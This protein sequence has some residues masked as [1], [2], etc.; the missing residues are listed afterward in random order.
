MAVAAL[1]CILP[2]LSLLSG[3]IKSAAMHTAVHQLDGSQVP[4]FQNPAGC[5]DGNQGTD[6][7]VR[8]SSTSHLEVSSGTKHAGKDATSFSLYSRARK[9]AYK[10]AC[11]R[12][13]QHG[14]TQ[15]RGQLLTAR[16]LNAAYVSD[17]LRP[18]KPDSRPRHTSESTGQRAR[19]R[20]MT[21]NCG[22]MTSDLY[23]VVCDWLSRAG[24]LDIVVL[25]ETHWGLGKQ[26]AT[27]TIP[28]W[29][30]V[31]TA[32]PENR[33]SGVAVAISTRVVPAS[34]ITF[35][36]WIPGRLLHV[37][38]DGLRASIDIVGIC[39]WV[40]Q[41][42]KNASTDSKRLSLW[43]QLGRLVGKLPRRNL[44]VLLGDFNTP[45]AHLP[46]HVGC[47]LLVSRTRSDGR[48]PAAALTGT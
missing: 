29:A 20:V 11:R 42:D 5:P 43:T 18:T 19:L 22:G 8:W 31:V 44:L 34:H 32:D 35:C 13:E 3:L 21:W 17:G 7:R 2:L 23:D 24:H 26:D 41:E 45:V 39:Q 12:A 25:Q 37:K 9:R 4:S 27:W 47:G 16:S 38:C 36:S 28:G 15:Y 33:Y 6:P 46:G 1:C 14:Q 40:K 30:L 48:G 10:R